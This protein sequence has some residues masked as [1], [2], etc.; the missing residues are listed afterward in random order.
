MAISNNYR[1]FI[2]MH[3]ANISVPPVHDESRDGLDARKRSQTTIRYYHTDQAGMPLEMT[4][5]DGSLQWRA[6]HS[7][8]GATHS[9]NSLGRNGKMALPD[10]NNAV[11]QPLRFQGQYFDAE[12]GL[13]FN[14]HRYYDPDVARFMTPDPISLRGGINFYRYAPNPGR[15]ADP[16]GLQ[17]V[18]LNLVPGLAFGYQA[19]YG[20]EVY[21][22][23]SHAAAGN[24][25]LSERGTITSILEP[26]EL[27][28]MIRTSPTYRRGKNILLLACHA[29]SG[30]NPYAQQLANE[31]D[32]NVLAPN[33]DM[34]VEMGLTGPVASLPEGSTWEIFI[35]HGS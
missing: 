17:G 10:A 35:P 21:V 31:L 20:S 11:H 4:D 34:G 25:V 8:W 13:H 28:E 3:E 26:E 6:S 16:L 24:P 14:R 23:L 30:N 27:A 22:V 5:A 7:A 1:T 2:H 32:S 29:G 15:W 9:L 12:T 33:G 18:D 19:N